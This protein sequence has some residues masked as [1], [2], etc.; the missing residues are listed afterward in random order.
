MNRRL[1]VAMLL[2][3]GSWSML[4]AQVPPRDGSIVRSA[5]AGVVRDS[6]GNPI[7]FA[8]VVVEGTELSAVSDDSGR[9]HIRGIVP[10]TVDVAVRRLGFAQVQ[11]TTTLAPDST[12]VVAVR[13]RSVQAL[14][15]VT[16][17]AAFEAP[18]LARSGYCER[19]RAGLGSF[20]PPAKVDSMAG[21][22]I[23]ASQLLR[24]VRG[25]ELS[26]GAGSR[27]SVHT[28]RLPDCLNLFV[29]GVHVEGEL[30]DNVGLSE[31]YAIEVYERPVIVP[32]EFQTKLPMKQGRGFTPKAGCG[33]LAVWTRARAP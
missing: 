21:R 3:A 30:D 11:F 27:C 15:A 13:L 23:T 10:G 20:V 32:T 33:A 4:E 17:K 22:V 28:R 8:A 14:G 12:L 29:N 31:V 7:K 26:C 9:F 24:D 19:E 1:L 25:I 16:V 5:L 6:L 18:L 2:T